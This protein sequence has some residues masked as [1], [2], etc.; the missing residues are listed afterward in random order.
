LTDADV[1]RKIIQVLPN[2]I[3]AS[4][5]TYLLNNEEFST[6]TPT[7]VLGKITAFEMYHKIGQE[8]SSPKLC[9]LISHEEEKKR[10]GKSKKI[11][12]S[13]S[14]S[15]EEDDEKDGDEDDQKQSSSSSDDEEMKMLIKRLER[16]MKKLNSKGIPITI[17]DVQFN[18]QSRNKFHVLAL[19][20]V[21]FA[22]V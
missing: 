14:S 18:N 12:S 22:S 7:K 15:E 11:E 19:I 17:E 8:P 2:K 13:S 10:K 3:Y 5:I 16:T 6:M 4:I 21:I 9:G 1:A 20:F